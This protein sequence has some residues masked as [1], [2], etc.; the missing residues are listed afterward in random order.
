MESAQKSEL[1]RPDLPWGAKL[2]T[3]KSAK[4][5]G[6]VEGTPSAYATKFAAV[7]EFARFYRRLND[8]PDVYTFENMQIFS[9]YLNKAFIADPSVGKSGSDLTSSMGKVSTADTVKKA[10]ALI[11]NKD[12][13][14]RAAEIILEFMS[15]VK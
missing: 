11:N 1:P 13:G 10:R 6:P 3:N 8:T 4:S 2:P 15:T 5:K 7:Y 14:L 9:E 12:H